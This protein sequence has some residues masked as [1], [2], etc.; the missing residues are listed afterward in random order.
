ML[1]F[2]LTQIARV[3]YLL[4]GIQTPIE[5]EETVEMINEEEIESPI[6]QEENTNG[7]INKEEGNEQ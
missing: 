5:A 6:S 3:I 2:L 1:S 4:R 7:L